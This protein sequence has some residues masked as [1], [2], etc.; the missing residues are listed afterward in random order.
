MAKTPVFHVRILPEL[1]ERFWELWIKVRMADPRVTHAEVFEMA[2]N[3][4]EREL[5]GK[6]E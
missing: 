1:K 5:D 3:A 4:L 2:V 6:G